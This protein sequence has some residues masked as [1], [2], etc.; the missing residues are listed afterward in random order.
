V[1]EVHES[2]GGPNPLSQFLALDYLTVLF[3][4]NLKNLKRLF[5]KPDLLPI[6]T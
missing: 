5:L 2:V 3:Q 6:P 1:V 4:K